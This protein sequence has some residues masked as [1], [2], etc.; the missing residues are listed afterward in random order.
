MTTISRTAPA[1]DKSDEYRPKEKR[2]SEFDA[3]SEDGRRARS[4]QR[5][6]SM[7]QGL[8]ALTR[9]RSPRLGSGRQAG[10]FPNPNLLGA[11][12]RDRRPVQG[13]WA[14]DGRSSKG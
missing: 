12:I 9:P 6:E 5:R 2:D 1:P 3:P 14:R 4:R 11:V 7:A 8:G 10:R 13:A